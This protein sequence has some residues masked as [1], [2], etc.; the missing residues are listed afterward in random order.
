MKMQKDLH[1]R[2]DTYRKTIKQWFGL[3]GESQSMAKTYQHCVDF[4]FENV[5]QDAGFY[6]T[7]YA[8]IDKK[9]L[10]SA[11]KRVAQDQS[12]A[13]DCDVAMS[14]DIPMKKCS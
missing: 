5:P 6:P 4:K 10:D 8:F 9:R 3:Q 1:R 7:C 11:K 14:S 12:E 13:E 2:W